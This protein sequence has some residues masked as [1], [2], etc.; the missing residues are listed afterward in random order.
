MRKLV[1][2][3]VLMAVGTVLASCQQSPKS[4]A[5][6]GA[7]K[8]VEEKYEAVTNPSE[9]GLDAQVAVTRME[10]GNNPGGPADGKIT[11]LTVGGKELALTSP[12]I[13]DGHWISTKDY[14]RIKIESGALGRGFVISL[15]PSQKASLLK[16]YKETRSS[17]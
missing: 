16:L 17:K 12:E 2:A 6:S 11:S 3:I 1:H 5:P 9:L 4:T 10:F 15:K 8:A 14:G 13:A 7:T